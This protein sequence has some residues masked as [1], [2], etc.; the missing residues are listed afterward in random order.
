MADPGPGYYRYTCKNYYT[1]NCGNWVWVNGSLCAAC[2][3][4]GRD[5]SEIMEHAE[6]QDHSFTSILHDDYLMPI[7]SPYCYISDTPYNAITPHFRH[8]PEND[9][10]AEQE[11]SSPTHA[12]MLRF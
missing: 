11:K 8:V 3:A 5:A 7:G 1:Y 10:N 4:A 6:N 12:S 9:P 2:V